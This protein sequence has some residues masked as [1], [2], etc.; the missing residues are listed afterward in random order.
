V[1][2]SAWSAFQVDTPQESLSIRGLMHVVGEPRAETPVPAA[3]A[4]IQGSTDAFVFT[5]T[6]DGVR[7]ALSPTTPGV[8][9]ISDGFLHIPLRLSIPG[10]YQFS[11]VRVIYRKPV[12]P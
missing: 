1:S 8:A 2:G 12:P 3:A 4:Q 10:T 6:A 7:I 11:D 9:D 5:P